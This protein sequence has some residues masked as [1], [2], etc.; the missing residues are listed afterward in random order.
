MK[1]FFITYIIAPIIIFQGCSESKSKDKQNLEI[2]YLDTLKIPL[3]DKFLA[4]YR[5]YH[6]A[7][8]E[9]DDVLVGYNRTSNSIEFINLRSK[10]IYSSV[11]FPSNGPDGVRRVNGIFYHNQDS[12]FILTDFHLILMNETGDRNLDLRI[13]RKDSDIKSF[14][15]STNLLIP[16]EHRPFNYIAEKNILIVPTN[17]IKYDQWTIPDYYESPI[18]AIVDLNEYQAELLPIFYPEE[19][20]MHSFGLKNRSFFT[21]KDE[22]IIIGFNNSPNLIHFDLETRQSIS[23]KINSKF[24]TPMQ[25]YQGA[26]ADRTDLMNY[27]KNYTTFTRVQY[28]QFR[29][30]YYLLSQHTDPEIGALIMNVSILDDFFDINYELTLPLKKY[31]NV[32]GLLE[33]GILTRDYPLSTDDQS[34]FLLINFEQK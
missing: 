31:L 12:I 17:F 20:T 1:L 4:N 30:C 10:K 22:S 24:Y 5:R 13:N 29:A 28:D 34:A 16:S 18:C 33:K 3:E 19:Y 9:K 6:Y 27:S 11:S 21:Y 32:I 7:K 15:F 14:D 23:N 2:V 8:R 26:M 25:P